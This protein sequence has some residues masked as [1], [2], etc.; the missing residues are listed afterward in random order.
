MTKKITIIVSILLIISSVTIEILIN[1]SKAQINES[2]G[3]FAGF[4]FVVGVILLL[5]LARKKKDN[6]C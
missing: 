6:P 3:F 1:Y 4:F 2:F 5:K